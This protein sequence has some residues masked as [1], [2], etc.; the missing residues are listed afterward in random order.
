MTAAAR[1]FWKSAA[2]EPVDGGYGVTLDGRALRTP[3]GSTLL[4][5][6]QRLGEAVQR[7]W[8]SQGE[9]IDAASMPMFQFTVTAIDRVTPQRD[10][11]IDEISHYGGSDLLCYR[12]DQD[13]RLKAHQDATWQPYLDWIADSRGI[14]LEVASGIMP[15]PQP[16]AALSRAR[17]LVAEFDDYH[18]AG[19]HSLVTVSG[20]LV[21]GMA[22]A[23]GHASPEEAGRAAFLDELWQQD[24]WGYDQEADR[25]IQSLQA[26]LEEARRYLG[27]LSNQPEER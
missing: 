1:R 12:E 22:M 26:A 16:E 19:L 10:A 9:T 6:T 21:L 24:K 23:D 8:D 5:P 15:R 27:L 13:T 17:R 7:E 3:A 14:S 2:I 25:R 11:V 20:S 18:L 4:A